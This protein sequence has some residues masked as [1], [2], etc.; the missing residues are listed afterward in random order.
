MAMDVAAD[1]GEVGRI[2]GE[3]IG[4]VTGH[5]RRLAGASSKRKRR[6]RLPDFAASYVPERTLVTFLRGAR[7]TV[8]LGRTTTG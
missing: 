8:T 2:G 1:G 4:G 6:S 7:S 5:R 3:Q